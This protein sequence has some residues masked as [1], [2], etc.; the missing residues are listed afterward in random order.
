M[1]RVQGIKD[2]EVEGASR[3]AKDKTDGAK[4]DE[5]APGLRKVTVVGPAK[6]RRRIGQQFGPE[7]REIEVGEAQYQALKAD[8]MLAVAG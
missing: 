7:P 8:P 1:S 4:Q 2:H 3:M 6:G 5:A